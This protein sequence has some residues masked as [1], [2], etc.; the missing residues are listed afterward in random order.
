MEN[1]VE[2]IKKRIDIVDF[3]GSFITL[4]KTGR[5][6]KAICPFH[7]E[8]T[9]SF[10]VSPERQIWH[11][12]GACN[13]GG[14]V[15]KF[16]MKWENITFVEAL[17]EL[18]KK[19]GVSLKRVSLEDFVWKKKERVLLL[20]QSAANFF[21]YL[22]TKKDLG[23]KARE[24]LKKRE[25]SE[26]IIEKFFL[27][28]AP[29][30]WDSLLRYLLKKG[31]KTD[32]IRQA[33]LVINSSKGDYD[34]FRGRLIFPIFDARNQIIGF[35]GRILDEAKDEPKYINTPETLLYRKR[36]T[37]FGIH[38]SKEAIK[39]ENQAILVEGEFDMIT[40]YAQGIGNIVAT[41]GTAITR[42]QLMLLKRFTNRL[43][44]SLDADMAG[45]EAMKKI[46]NEAEGIDI[47]LNVVVLDYAK[48]PDEAVRKDVVRFKK[49]LK[50]P[51][52]IYD[53]IIDLSKKN[54][55]EDTAYA[56]KQ[57]IDEVAPIIDRIQ[58]PIIRAFYIKKLSS[59][60]DLSERAIEQYFKQKR[61]IEKQRKKI[62]FF[63]SKEKKI[64][65]EV[66]LE[67]FLLS[68]F[69][70]EKEKESLF[71]KIT[72]LL[73]DDDFS[74]PAYGKIFEALKRYYQDNQEKLKNYVFAVKDFIPYLEAS[75]IPTFDEIYLYASYEEKH[76]FLIDRVI[77]EIKKYALKRKITNLL[78]E[79]DSKEKEE[80]LKL[81]N[82]KLTEIEKKMIKLSV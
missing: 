21:H 41:K 32:E 60:I 1:P 4:K 28:Y 69:F 34:R 37:L 75:L 8:K 54:H 58:N 10:I 53:F 29:L 35:S 76:D 68:Y 22:L 80:K 9:P 12:F 42:E 65:R 38:L 16:L 27:G 39:K 50:K 19:T 82:R 40:P 66:I 6:F 33:G 31:F 24:Y 7:Q 51:Q 55:N 73:S 11:C 45:L 46:I 15:I 14:D 3:I 62:S 44:L 36:E 63:V 30:S 52:P 57:I 23:K 2:E 56:K 79:E 61:L 71:Y 49:L 48:D 26:N 74:I 18:A 72:E 25:I 81:F 59:L 67:K 5:N 43:T 13:E 70:Q 47:E 78:Q 20:N 64:S 77:Y 17:S